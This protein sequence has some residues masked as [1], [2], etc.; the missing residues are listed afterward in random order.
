VNREW[1]VAAAESGAL[2]E[3]AR[4]GCGDGEVGD[5]GEQ[6]TSWGSSPSGEE[7]AADDD[8]AKSRVRR[9]ALWERTSGQSA[10][11]VLYRVE[12]VP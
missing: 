7:D 1:P 4:V 8:A 10:M 3:L 11:R 12:T 9:C 2:D 6:Y 5:R